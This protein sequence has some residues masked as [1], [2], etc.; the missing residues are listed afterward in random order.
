VAFIGYRSILL[1]ANGKA[2]SNEWAFVVL[3]IRGCRNVLALMAVMV[4]LLTVRAANFTAHHGVA[5]YDI[6]KTLYGKR[7]KA[8]WLI[9]MASLLAILMSHT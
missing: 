2:G 8:V 3:M 1:T 9:S 4:P 6:S 5:I 7:V